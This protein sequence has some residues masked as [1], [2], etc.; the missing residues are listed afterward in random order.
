MFNNKICCLD[1]NIK[2]IK[3]YENN[4]ITIYYRIL[5]FNKK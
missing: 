5:N 3:I 4:L 2:K 1:K